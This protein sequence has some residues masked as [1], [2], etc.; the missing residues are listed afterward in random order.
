MTN[1]RETA[2]LNHPDKKN[3]QLYENT[4]GVILFQ[5]FAVA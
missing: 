3:A 5:V 2:H 4:K 1:N